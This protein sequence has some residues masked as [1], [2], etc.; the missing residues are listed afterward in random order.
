MPLWRSRVYPTRS[1]VQSAEVHQSRYNGQKF[2]KQKSRLRVDE[3]SILSTGLFCGI[4]YQKF[5]DPHVARKDNRTIFVTQRS[6]ASMSRKISNA[7]QIG[8]GIES[9]KAS[10]YLVKDANCLQHSSYPRGKRGNRDAQGWELMRPGRD[11]LWAR[12]GTKSILRPQK[13]HM[14]HEIII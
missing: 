2:Q 10:F 7:Q 9:F 11:A 4:C 12:P 6:M 14:L 1:R 13:Y 5:H 8:S 3:N